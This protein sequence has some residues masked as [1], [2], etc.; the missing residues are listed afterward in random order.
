[1]QVAVAG[2]RWDGGRGQPVDMV[3]PSKYRGCFHT[4]AVG[5]GC[6]QVEIVGIAARGPRPRG[7]H[8]T[9]TDSDDLD[10]DYTP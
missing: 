1:M 4:R 2:R 9:L 3:A 7:L 5:R 10:G 6:W 8:L